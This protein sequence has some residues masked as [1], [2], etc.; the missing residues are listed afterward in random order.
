[1]KIF[2]TDGSI[3]MEIKAVERSASAIDFCG[4]VT[5]AMPV[6]GRLT[7]DEARSLF[8]LIRPWQHARR[9]QNRHEFFASY[10]NLRTDAAAYSPIVCGFALI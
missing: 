5:G 3:L 7:S 8:E 1:M 2:N 10:G 4:T 9:L 6:K